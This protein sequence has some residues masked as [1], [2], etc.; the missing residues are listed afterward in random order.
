MNKVIKF[1][2]FCVIHCKNS[3]NI[4]CVNECNLMLID[5]FRKI[6]EYKRDINV[7]LLYN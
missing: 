2:E 6:S 7:K 5:F 1:N 3:S 4:N